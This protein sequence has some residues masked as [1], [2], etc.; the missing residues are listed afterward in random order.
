MSKIDKIK[1]QIGWFKVIFGILSAIAVSLTG[2]IAS[3]Y[4]K[5]SPLLLTLSFVALFGALLGIIVI[6]RLALKKID[7][8][9]EL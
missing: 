1:E 3:S 9:E 8:L 4:K 6:N 7:E 2:F 5:I